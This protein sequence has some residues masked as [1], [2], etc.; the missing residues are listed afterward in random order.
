MHKTIQLPKMSL[1]FVQRIL[2]AIFRTWI[3]SISEP[4]NWVEVPCA[5][6][7]PIDSN[8]WH[9]SAKTLKI[10]KIS[11]LNQF[12]RSTEAFSKNKCSAME[13]V[14]YDNNTENKFTVGVRLEC[15]WNLNFNW[16]ITWPQLLFVKHISQIRTMSDG[17]M[18]IFDS[19]KLL[20]LSL[21]FSK[22]ENSKL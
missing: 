4:L 12:F 3:L 6:V 7:V 10:R 22:I 11:I 17:A 21:L 19:L 15:D 8:R 1:S 13:H 5:W 2:A 14:K 20:M 18:V 9:W 16:S